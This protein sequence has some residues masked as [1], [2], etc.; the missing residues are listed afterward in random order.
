MCPF[1]FLDPRFHPW[2]A[3]FCW[4]NAQ[5]SHWWSHYIHETSHSLPT[6]GDVYERGK[7]GEGMPWMPWIHLSPVAFPCPDPN[8]SPWP[9]RFQ[10]SPPAPPQWS[11][12]PCRCPGPCWRRSGRIGRGPQGPPPWKIYHHKKWRIFRAPQK[13]ADLIPNNLEDCPKNP[14]RSDNNW[15]FGDMFMRI[16][17]HGIYNRQYDICV[18]VIFNGLVMMGMVIHPLPWESLEGEC[19]SLSMGCWWSSN[20]GI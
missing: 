4:L 8:G 16:G 6:M 17:C 9:G 12:G 10:N 11:P 5:I 14:P 18:M 7:N 20:A 19:Q 1:W 15:K 13:I 3:H 2:N